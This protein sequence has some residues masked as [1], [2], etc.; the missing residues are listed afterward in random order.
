VVSEQWRKRVRSGGKGLLYVLGAG[1]LLM[2]LYDFNSIRSKISL[3][4]NDIGSLQDD[5][6]S[7]QTDVSS[8][9]NDV[10]SIEGAIEDQPDDEADPG[11]KVKEEV[12]RYQSRRLRTASV[13]ALLRHR[14]HSE[15]WR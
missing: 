11:R 15:N 3:M 8:I 14:K 7:I 13:A 2:I 1:Y 12:N 5:M 10:S 6:D 9:Q 4:E